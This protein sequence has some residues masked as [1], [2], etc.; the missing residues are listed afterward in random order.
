MTKCALAALLLFVASLALAAP[1]PDTPEG[2]LDFAASLEATGDTYRAATE[3]LRVLHHFGDSRD[4]KV[5]AL[6]GLSSAYAKAGR[7]Q[8]AAETLG[9]LSDEKPDAATRLLLGDAL[10]RAGR[11]RDAAILLLTGE[12]G[13]K[14]KRLGT[15]AW[16][17]AGG[18]GEIPPQADRSV[19]ETYRNLPRKDPA[20][21]GIL[22]ALLPGAGHLYVDRPRDGAVALVL[23]A[24]FLWG[25]VES[26]KREE[27]ALAGV[28]GAAEVFWYSGTI[29]GAVN[30][31]GKWNRREEERF[32]DRTGAEARP[33]WSLAPSAF[34]DGRGLSLS[35]NW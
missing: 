20:A 33:K 1:P 31:A 30:G 27:W 6:T 5:K 35:F 19:V 2:M 11:D 23:N 24:L 3:Y 26:V 7:W 32:F 28:L 29:V 10:M 9:K 18:A 34:G 13:E 25:T 4:I 16:I 17:K 12:V 14:E 21:A 8:D 15:L 22:T